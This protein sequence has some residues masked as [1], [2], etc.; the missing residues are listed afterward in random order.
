MS[1]SE[2][3]PKQLIGI[4]DNYEALINELY[5]YLLMKFPELKQGAIPE[6][7]DM[8]V[9]NFWR[10]SNDKNWT[11]TQIKKALHLAK[12][13]DQIKE[14]LYKYLTQEHLTEFK[15]KEIARI[16]RMKERDFIRLKNSERQWRHQEVRAA[17]EL[18]ERWQS[19]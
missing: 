5:E 8:S 9:A 10:K 11:S 15:V 1:I 12:E 19:L 3:S 17:L 16:L 18:I 6:K 7:L 14:D 4:V 2:K 13:Y